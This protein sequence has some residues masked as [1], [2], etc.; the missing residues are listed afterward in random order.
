MPVSR[1]TA[2]IK[3][4]YKQTFELKSKGKSK[5]RH[6]LLVN[7]EDMSV[8]EPS[9]TNVQQTLGGAYVTDFGVGL[10]QVNISGTTGYSLRT[11]ADG[12]RKDGYQEVKDLRRKLYRNFLETNDSNLEMYWYNWEDEEYYQIVPLSFRISRNKSEPLLYRY[13]F[14]FTALRKL[15][16]P[17][18][19][20]PK[21]D[22]NTLNQVNI[23]KYAS[24]SLSLVSSLSEVRSRLFR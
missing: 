16:K 22:I 18:A 1:S 11:N 12:Q 6:T 5:Y 21:H 19:S 24:S 23:S 20:K 8:Q 17:G 9:R 7:P 4:Y 13:E 15:D 10:H 2:L 14:Q 3:R